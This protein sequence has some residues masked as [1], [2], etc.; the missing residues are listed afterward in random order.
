MEEFLDYC[1]K[2]KRGKKTK[3]NGYIFTE[4]D[5]NEFHIPTEKLSKP[6]FIRFHNKKSGKKRIVKCWSDKTIVNI[7]QTMSHPHIYD[8][9][10][11]LKLKSDH[12][13]KHEMR[14]LAKICKKIGYTGFHNE[15]ITLPDGKKYRPDYYYPDSKGN[16]LILIEV[17]E[18]HHTRVG[19]Q[20]CDELRQEELSS[21]YGDHF[22]RINYDIDKINDNEL[23]LICEEIKMI[24][25]YYDD[26]ISIERMKNE[27]EDFTQVETF[28]QKFGLCII[29]ETDPFPFN[30]NEAKIL[31]QITP[32]SEMEKRVTSYFIDDSTKETVETET[33]QEDKPEDKPEAD[34]SDSSD[35]D[36]EDWSDGE[37]EFK[38]AEEDIEEKTTTIF[39]K[40]IDY[41]IIKKQI[42]VNRETFIEIALKTDTK[43]GKL[44]FNQFMKF[45]KMLKKLFQIIIKR[46]RE[47]P[48][49]VNQQRIERAYKERVF[50]PLKLKLTKLEKEIKRLKKS[51]AISKKKS[52]P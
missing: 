9:Q 21:L 24:L 41:K 46:S 51:I 23:D 28:A 2:T 26:D 44:I 30:L 12:R 18:A 39:T 16:P 11:E 15:S 19:N 17:D 6:S 3:K 45:E 32:D 4:K 10:T 14:I 40:D 33:K 5:V 50:L 43:T 47:T 20:V 25:E 27:F 22:Y 29:D 52:T 49:F 42:Y 34:S 8:L 13:N 7:I 38:N 36:S 31:L 35:D 37:D 48:H 1:K